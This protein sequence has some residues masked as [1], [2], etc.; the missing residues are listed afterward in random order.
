MVLRLMRSLLGAVAVASCGNLTNFRDALVPEVRLPADGHAFAEVVVLDDFVVLQAVEHRLDAVI[1]VH[2]AVRPFH[3]DH[4]VERPRNRRWGR[5]NEVAGI[6][7]PLFVCL[8]QAAGLGP[9]LVEVPNRRR[10]W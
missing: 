5:L 9:A 3:R 6:G 4:D 1:D 8:G 10:H 2:Q 7:P